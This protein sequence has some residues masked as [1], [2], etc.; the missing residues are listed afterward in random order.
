MH[1]AVAALN[2][3]LGNVGKTV[4]LRRRAERR[5]LPSRTR[6]SPT[7]VAPTRAPARCKTLVVLGGNPVYDAPADL[8]F[9]TAPARSPT[10]PPR[11]ARRRDR[12]VADWHLPQAHF[13][14]SWGDAR[15]IGGPLSS[16]SR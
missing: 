5:A 14:E 15:A 12:G 2:A 3:A 11:A 13:L 9:A 6:G 16:C 8:D 1:A 4:T 10:D 7:L